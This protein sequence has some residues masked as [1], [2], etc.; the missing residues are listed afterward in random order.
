V[1][2]CSQIL[3]AIVLTAHL[4][5]TIELFPSWQKLVNDE[6]VV[7]V[8]HAIHLY[9]GYLGAKFLK[10]HGSSWGYDPYFMAGYPKTPVYDSSSGPAELFQLLAGGTYSPRAYKIGTFSLVALVPFTIALA[11]W[12][13]GMRLAAVLFATTWSVWFWWAGFADTLVRT[14]LVAF[15]WGS[16]VAVL[17]PALLLRWCAVPRFANW[18][19]LALLASLGIQAHSIF[20]L[21]AAVPLAAGYAWITL[22]GCTAELD[23]NR[24]PGWRWHAATWLALAFALA[25]TC[26][27]WWPLIKFL[28]LK[29]A[30]D[31]F[32]QHR[33]DPLDPVPLRIVKLALM[34]YL[35][36]DAF[37]PLL[38]LL[39]GMIG[40]VRWCVSGRGLQGAM[41]GSQIAGL[42]LLTFAGSQW[43]ATRN[44]EPLRFQVPLGLAL[45]LAAGEGVSVVVQ[46][47]APRR[48]WGTKTV[49]LT[50]ALSVLVLALAAAV[51]F[52]SLWWTRVGLDGKFC[53]ASSWRST[54]NRLHA[55]QPLAVGLEPEMVELADW[56]RSNCDGS[57]RI[58]F[59]DQLR[60]LENLNPSAP[61]S[62]H[63][64]PLL[65]V[66]TGREFV[67]GLYHLAFI[68]HRRAAFGDWS[69]AGRN[70]REWSAD[71]LQGL[72]EQYNIGWAITWSRAS[73]LKQGADYL[74]PLSTDI[75]GRMPF[76]E[77]V[78]KIRRHTT[79]EDEAEY[80]IFRVHRTPNYFAK[81]R[82]RVVRADF[83][84][85]EL[86]NIEP[87]QGEI[88]LRYHWQEEFAAD[89]PVPLTR[90]NS[91][92][93]SVG[94][95]RIITDQAIDRLVLLNSYR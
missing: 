6:P 10:E 3:V 76:C 11:S 82:G 54:A 33:G 22:V 75:L 51:T 9:H 91:P 5:L 47:L 74:M 67:G 15:V 78:A 70:V 7:S 92:G 45:C 32:M 90:A 43:Q 83:N 81:G 26:A 48:L 84:R 39:F 49:K 62:I 16:A 63:W 79:R 85:I 44:L 2:W 29:T 56:I 57:A 14:G 30:S 52:P 66:L 46:G 94:F 37:V 27:W 38:L 36:A 80:A 50:W 88:V 86:A 34:Y 77:P 21:M 13:Y 55:V 31:I 71:E 73:P 12:G 60:L 25:A 53:P 89:P 69:L 65:P 87:D 72:F 24:R 19:L 93:D 59:E 8:D 18:L 40:L 61:E 4:W 35:T 95:I 42:A 41:L 64:T 28:P 68:P 20:A 17:V 58:L 23:G 1:S